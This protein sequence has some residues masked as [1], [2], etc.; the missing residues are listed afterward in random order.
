M[1]SCL[2]HC[3][4]DKRLMGILVKFCSQVTTREPLWK[5]NG[6]SSSRDIDKLGNMALRG[7]P[8]NILG[9]GRDADFCKL[10]RCYFCDR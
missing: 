6:G 2:G 10:M 9:G 4:I 7:R 1:Q 8:L 3:D 5:T